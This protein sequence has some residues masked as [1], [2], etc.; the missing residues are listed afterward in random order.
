MVGAITA[1]GAIIAGMMLGARQPD[2]TTQ[3]RPS[4]PDPPVAERAHTPRQHLS[5]GQQRARL[6]SLLVLMCALL[7][8]ELLIG[9]HS[10]R[11]LRDT[12]SGLGAWGPLLV[13]GAYVTLT[14]AMVP[15]P[16]LAGAS[17]LLFGTALGTP[18]SIISATLGASLAFLI[19]RSLARSAVPEFT[20]PRL[21]AWANAIHSHGFLAVLYAR[22]APGV[23][24]A[25]VS[26]GAGLTRVRFG[27]FAAA[28]FIGAAPRA[29]AYTAL[30][31]NL[32][33]YSSPEAIAA[34]AVLITMALGGV[35]TAWL[36][37]RR[38]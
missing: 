21:R 17:G 7:L 28:T 37:R 26:Y 25:L 32:G 9:P 12:F 24:F 34:I 30:G 18:V 11:Q 27:V 6:A 20:A 16:I 5:R 33:N 14:C 8:G 13:G 31:G 19:S 29:F 2:S 10:A 1:A 36:V 15:G 35:M 38:R 22:I 3:T 23:P 4:A